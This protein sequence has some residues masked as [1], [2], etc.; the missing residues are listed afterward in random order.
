MVAG[1]REKMSFYPT[2]DDGRQFEAGGQFSLQTI[3][4]SRI[5]MVQKSGFDIFAAGLIR[6]ILLCSHSEARRESAGQSKKDRPG[7][8]AVQFG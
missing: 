4:E 6:A 2:D 1:N 3:N 5:G 8:I 7:S